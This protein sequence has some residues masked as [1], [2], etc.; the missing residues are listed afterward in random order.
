MKAVEE[1]CEQGSEFLAL[2]LIDT[3]RYLVGLVQRI[4]EG[5]ESQD[6]LSALLWTLSFSEAF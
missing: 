6:L 1:F 4:M 3:H 2:M 5:I